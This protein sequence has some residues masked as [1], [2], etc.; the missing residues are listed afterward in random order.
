MKLEHQLLLNTKPTANGRRYTL[1]ALQSIADKINQIGEGRS[2]GR[3]G[4][5]GVVELSL[6]DVSFIISNPIIKSDSL[7][8]DVD[9][10]ST[11]EGEKL[12]PM[13]NHVVFRPMTM[14]ASNE[15]TRVISGNIVYLY[16]AAVLKS[17]DTLNLDDNDN[18]L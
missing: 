9:V 7:Y 2:L 6:H 8:I 10:L 18:T 5:T 16:A 15:D 13:L 14:L 3:N 17:E 12:K 4:Y 11:P 1:E